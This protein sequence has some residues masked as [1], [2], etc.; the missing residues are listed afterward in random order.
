MLISER[1]APRTRLKALASAAIATLVLAPFFG[2]PA[3]ASAAAGDG[4]LNVTLA[5]KTGTPGFDADDAAGHDSS[6]DNDIV[7]T[8][9]TVA[10]TVSIR[11]EG[12]DQTNPAITFTL[13]QG[14]ELVQLPPFCLTGSSVTPAS[15]G[16]PVTPVTGT[17]YQALPT[18][19]VVCVVADQTQGTSLDY[20]F[21]SKVRPEVPHGTTLD[22]VTAS[23]TSDQVTTPAVSNEVGHS[24]SAA[25]DFDVSKR[26]SATTANA[27][28][29][30]QTP[31]FVPCAFDADRL[32]RE[33][34]YPLTINTPPGGKGLTPLA[35][36]IQLTEN[37]TPAS[38][39]GP[40]VWAQAVAAAGSE[41]AAVEAYAPRLTACRDITRSLFYS[42][43]WS[44]L[45][46]DDDVR[47]ISDS[48]AIDC[49]QPGGVG[50]SVGI[51]ITGADTTGYHVPP[52]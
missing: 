10:Y 28:P 20:E 18:Q 24:V 34:F 12:E 33:I 23:A 16:A 39:Y 8:N 26:G 3:P 50:T 31:G 49:Q 38:F 52:R 32:C 13:P 45:G 51:T 30:G 1:I 7:R 19:T 47:E 27:G 25:A 43:P 48:G 22:P 37:I 4:T 42:L 15:I 46:G 41:A 36:P 17:S 6:A 9:D 35:S 14:E 5:Q 2:A 21:L 40:T 44:R 29:Y 11:Y